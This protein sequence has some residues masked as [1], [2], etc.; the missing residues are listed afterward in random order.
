MLNQAPQQRRA[1][2]GEQSPAYAQEYQKEEVKV[3]DKR[4]GLDALD[5]IKYKDRV[6]LVRV[7]EQA[8]LWEDMVNQ[9][10]Y[11]LKENP[12][13][14]LNKNARTSMQIGC[15][16]FVSINREAFFKIEA[17]EAKYPDFRNV[18]AAYRETVEER[19]R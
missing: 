18:I 15:K 6:F 12:D 14:V 4:I 7:A 8:E 19:V 11:V 3:G 16:K 10:E 2:S 5:K 9:C 13:A 17:V 1:N